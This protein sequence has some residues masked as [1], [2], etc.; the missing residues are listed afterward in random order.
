MSKIHVLDG[1]DEG[2]YKVAIHTTVPGG[3]NSAGFTWKSVI[4]N[5]GTILAVGTDPGNITSIEKDAIDA[6]DTFEIVVALHAETNAELN[7]LADK[8]ITEKQAEVGRKYK[9]FGKVIASLLMGLL[10]TSSVQ[11]ATMSKTADIVL[12][13]HQ[14]ITHPG[15]VAGSTTTVTTDLAVTIV[16]FHVSVEA[17]AN[18]NSGSFLVQ[19]SAS[20]SNNEDWV[21]IAEFKTTVSTAATEALTATE[22]SG[23]TVLA[24]ASTTGFVA[25]DYV[26]IQDAGT[27]ADSEWG[28]LQEI[29]TDT[30]L[31]LIDG[32]TTGK[33]SSDVAWNDADIFVFQL[34][35]SAV[36]RYR[37]IFQHEGGTGANVHIKALGVEADSF[38]ALKMDSLK[39]F[40]FLS[41][42]NKFYIG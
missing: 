8:T 9:W 13:T 36:T 6:G 40:A 34:D 26:Y 10:L 41:E 18:T 28:R 39:I 20:A 33:D 42:S 23:E 7:E 21:S 5:Q 3:S 31:D 30:S 2:N 17:T 16:M 4:K 32:L 38:G 15:T 19:V 1:D 25:G 24:V 35:L 27:L 11:A 12:L 22:A 37:V 29:V 14:A